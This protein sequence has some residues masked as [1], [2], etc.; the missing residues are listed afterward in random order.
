MRKSTSELF[1]HDVGADESDLVVRFDV[2]AWIRG[3][4][5]RP[6]VSR[7]SCTDEGPDIVCDGA[8]ERACE[9]GSELSTRDCS[10]LGQLCVPGEGCRERLIIERDS[11]AYRSLRNAVVSGARP[12]FDW[13]SIP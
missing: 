8:M 11:E 6:F 5:F 3:V 1:F 9:S 12:S 2:S 13:N 10:E 4:D 7:E